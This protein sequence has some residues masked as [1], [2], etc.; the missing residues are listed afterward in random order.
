MY[1][2]SEIIIK[3]ANVVEIN[4]VAFD[5][6]RPNIYKI[7]ADTVYPTKYIYLFSYLGIS[8]LEKNNAIIAIS[9]RF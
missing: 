2:D 1:K 7:I 3:I 4:I 5:V 8:N 6:I 9:N